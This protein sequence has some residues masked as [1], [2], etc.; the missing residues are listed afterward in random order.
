[1]PRRLKI[2]NELNWSYIPGI[3]E[4]SQAPFVFPRGLLLSAASTE[5]LCFKVLNNVEYFQSASFKHCFSFSF[6]MWIYFTLSFFIIYVS[7]QIMKI[8]LHSYKLNLDY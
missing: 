4:N 5:L 2:G 6:K 1:M 3:T 7:T 8:Y